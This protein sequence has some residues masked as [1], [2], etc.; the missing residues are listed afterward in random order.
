MSALVKYYKLATKFI[1]DYNG[2]VITKLT[3]A[4][5]LDANQTETMR[6][7]L[8]EAEELDFKKLRRRGK[9]KAKA[10][11]AVTRAPTQYNLFVQAKIKE[12]KKAQPD[13]D[14]KKLMVEAAAAWTAKKQAASESASM[15]PTKKI[16]K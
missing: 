11:S 13:M 10:E 4:L 5:E 12:L 6:N 3:N 2:E 8:K 7:T 9:S 15:S 16:K 1:S 14:R